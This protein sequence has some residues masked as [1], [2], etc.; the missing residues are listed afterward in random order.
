MIR[1][2]WWCGLHGLTGPGRVPFRSTAD[3]ATE[4]RP[5]GR[6]RTDHLSPDNDRRRRPRSS[7][8]AGPG[9]SCASTAARTDELTGLNNLRAFREQA[10]TMF[11]ATRRHGLPL[12]ALLVD[13]DH[14]KQINDT[15][16]HAAGDRVLQAVAQGLKKALREADLCGRLGG[17]EFAV[18]LAGTDLHAALQVAE[19]LRLAVQ[20]LVVA[21]NDAVL[22]VTISVGVAEADAACADITTLLAQADA[23]MYHAKANGRNRVHG[24]SA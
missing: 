6:C 1:R 3:L 10:D 21:I 24:G 20:A 19:K 2:R 5:R 4:L 13:I 14:F 17:E 18:L 7:S 23:A 12:C 22:H 15:H 16:G 11:T 9:T 8:P